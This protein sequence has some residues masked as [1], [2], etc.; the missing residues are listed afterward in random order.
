MAICIA[1]LLSVVM[2]LQTKSHDEK[3]KVAFVASEV[4]SIKED[5]EMRHR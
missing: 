4:G 1:S 3:R 5:W 2:E